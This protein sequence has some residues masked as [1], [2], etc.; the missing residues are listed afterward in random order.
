MVFILLSS[1]PVSAACSDWLRTYNGPANLNDRGQDV[2]VDGSNNIYVTGW[3]YQGNPGLDNWITI[4][5]DT[6]GNVLWTK[7]WDNPTYNR[8][9]QSHGIAYSSFGTGHVVVV[10]STA[11]TPEGYNILIRKINALDGS[12]VWQQSFNGASSLDDVANAVAIDLYGNVYITGYTIQSRPGGYQDTDLIVQKYDSNGNFIWSRF[13]DNSNQHETG[14][15]IAADIYGNVYVAGGPKGTGGKLIVLKIDPNG[16]ILW[17]DNSYSGPMNQAIGNSI[18]SDL[19]GTTYVG[20]WERV[21][22]PDNQNILIRKYDTNG[23]VLWTNSFTDA[24]DLTQVA[25]D[26][27]LSPYGVWTTG[28]EVSTGPSHYDVLTVQ[29]DVTN[30]NMLSEL[31]YDSGG[32]ADE[33]F[34]ISSDLSG[35]IIIT[36]RQYSTATASDIFVKKYCIG[37]PQT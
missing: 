36:G 30:G 18:I 12:L 29:F 23:N 25:E 14:G 31:Y 37:D 21:P 22:Y 16:N 15:G 17:Q 34:G 32:V 11:V 1:I 35:S 9:D 2:A 19:Y 7:T 8:Q 28:T 3:Y 6:N 26:I 27:T 24:N 4:K 5:Y 33:G 10:G 13:W 20:G